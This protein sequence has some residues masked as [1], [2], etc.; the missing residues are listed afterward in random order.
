[1]IIGILTVPFNNNYGGYLQTFAL[2]QILSRMGHQTILID[3]KQELK[4]SLY[5]WLKS[6]LSNRIFGKKERFYNQKSMEHYHFLKGYKMQTFVD[7]NLSSKTLPIYS[8]NDFKILSNINFDAVIVGSDQVWRPKYVPNIY[9]YFLEYLP[10]NIWRISYAASFGTDSIEYDKQMLE[11]CKKLLLA[12]KSVSIREKSGLNLLNRYFSYAKGQIV[13]DPTLLLSQQDYIKLF[14][15]QLVNEKKW[16]FAYILDRNKQ[17]EDII[18]KISKETSDSLFDI[19]NIDK[20]SPYYSIEDWLKGIFY[21]T[22]VV[23]DSFHGTV[24]SILFNKPFYVI[25]NEKRG[26]SRIIDLLSTF[27][28]NDRLIDSVKDIDNVINNINWTF[29][30]KQLN[31]ERKKSLQFLK[32]ALS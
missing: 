28:L 25:G 13:L 4:M 2:T 10:Q 15:K 3:R 14:D 27:K 5:E 32:E 18:K 31:Q 7:K 17:K 19:M 1:M 22:T 6:Y 26:N 16:T 23:T 30:N 12:F 8:T 11:H 29:V 20:Y 9:E 21:A 24:F